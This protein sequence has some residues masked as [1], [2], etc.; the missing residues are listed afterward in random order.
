M[1]FNLAAPAG[2]ASSFTVGIEVETGLATMAGQPRLLAADDAGIDAV[3][4]GASHEPLG[5]EGSEP[6]CLRPVS[7]F[8]R[9]TV[10]LPGWL[11]S[12][13]PGIGTTNGVLDER[14]MATTGARGQGCRHLLSQLVW[15][16]RWNVRNVRCMLLVGEASYLITE[17]KV[18]LRCLG[19]SG[20]QVR[21]AIGRRRWRSKISSFLVRT[22]PNYQ[23]GIAWCVRRWVRNHR[24]GMSIPQCSRRRSVCSVCPSIRFT[25]HALRDG[26]CGL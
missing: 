16:G 19:G 2:R 21:H 9:R 20:E 24:M 22:P 26:E 7:A 6:V 13:V 11:R 1:K 25:L 18:G 23:A 4:R 8:G 10:R 3:F 15:G 5:V 17:E 12:F 14:A